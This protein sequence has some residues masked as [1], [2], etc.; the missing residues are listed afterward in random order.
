MS[1][2]DEM[3]AEDLGRA[4]ADAKGVLPKI[5]AGGSLADARTESGANMLLLYLLTRWGRIYEPGSPAR[6]ADTE[7]FQEEVVD[8]Y[9]SAGCAADA[10]T[11][12]RE[13]KRHLPRSFIEMGSLPDQVSARSLVAHLE[14]HVAQWSEDLAAQLERLH[15]RLG[16]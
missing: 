6:L 16:A 15:D 4:D 8:A 14:E 11:P 1:L 13:V 2:Q 9:L 10:A 5:R 3:R 7:A 12:A